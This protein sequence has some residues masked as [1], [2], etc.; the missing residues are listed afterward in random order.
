MYL[1][2][3]MGDVDVSVAIVVSVGYVSGC[4]VCVMCPGVVSVSVVCLWV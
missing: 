4:C 1:A 2:V 3:V